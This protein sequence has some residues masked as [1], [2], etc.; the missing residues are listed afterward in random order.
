[1]KI[2]NLDQPVYTSFEEARDKL[3]DMDSRSYTV[4]DSLYYI[5]DQEKRINLKDFVFSGVVEEDETLSSV[6]KVCGY[7]GLRYLYEIVNHETKEKVFPVGSECIKNFLNEAHDK[8][9]KSPLFL[10]NAFTG[11]VADVLNTET[12]KIFPDIVECVY[13]GNLSPKQFAVLVESGYRAG[14]PLPYMLIRPNRKEFR[15]IAKHYPGQRD[16]SWTAA[17]FLPDKDLDVRGQLIKRSDQEKRLKF[18][19]NCLQNQPNHFR[20][21]GICYSTEIE[22]LSRLK[23]PLS[24]MVSADVS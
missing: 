13:Q 18:E 8:T 9:M 23:K 22:K 7:V 4:Y 10:A 21:Y 14:I 3:V 20:F 11:W 1:M 6:C 15:K 16:W 5:R 2:F 24:F 17:E 19:L 12:I